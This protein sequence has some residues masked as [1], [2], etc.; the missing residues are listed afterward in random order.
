MSTD[1][2]PHVTVEDLLHLKRCE[3]PRAEFWKQFDDEL[4]AKQLAA[5]VEKRP[6]WAGLART[7]RSS[8]RYTAPL[9]TAVALAL[10]MAG[11]HEYR[12]V[13]LRSSPGASDIGDIPAATVSGP[14]SAMAANAADSDAAILQESASPAVRRARAATVAY[15]ETVS[16]GPSSLHPWRVAARSEAWLDGSDT[17]SARSIEANLAAVRAA[18]PELI[19]NLLSLSQRYDSQLVPESRRPAA[20]PLAQINP[21]SDERRSRLLAE[22]TPVATGPRPAAI[23]A[24]DRLVRSLS[25]DRTYEESVSR[26]R[27]GGSDLPSLSIKF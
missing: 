13:A 9:G 14:E 15:R 21:I 17:P 6:W 24:S 5:I 4:R 3:A 22:A 19:R 2:K 27:V 12:V 18:Q 8:S 7:F 10:G 23:P 20:E 1:S 16:P 11:F 26:Y 25:D